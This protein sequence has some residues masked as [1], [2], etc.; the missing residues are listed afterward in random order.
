MKRLIIITLCTLAFI[1]CTN[2]GHQNVT[3]S[4]E[5]LHEWYYNVLLNGEND[6]TTTIPDYAYSTDWM[7]RYVQYI[8]QHFVFG[9]VKGGL[10]FG[11]IDGVP[12]DCEN[13][14]M[15][16]VDND[17]IPE[18]LLYGGCWA[19]GSIILTQHG[20]KVFASPK[21]RFSY[22]K[23]ADGLLHSRW[24]HS[25]DVWGEIYEMKNGEFTEIASYNL[26]TD[27]S[28]D[29]SKV[30]NYGLMLDSMK[31]QY[32]G[33]E[34][35]DSVVSISEIELNGKRIGACFG[36]NQCVY[37]IGFAQVKQTL[38]A[39]YYSKGTSTFF[40]ITSGKAINEL[41]NLFK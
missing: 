7:Q 20:G 1:S 25:D 38:D 27:L 31:C 23:G 34:I 14:T 2:K 32:A 19:S 6:T 12:F 40:P 18:L 24:M 29:T 13:W 36:Y 28:V 4:Q 35:G 3:E 33:G 41:F 21:G 16:Y 10:L 15:A 8:E 11:E 37:C 39:I 5:E 26:N 22:I 9:G 17:T 30:G